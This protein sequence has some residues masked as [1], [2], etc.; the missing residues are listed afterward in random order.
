M[1]EDAITHEDAKEEYDYFFDLL[2]DFRQSNPV[3]FK[4]QYKKAREPDVL[5]Y[6]TLD[7]AERRKLAN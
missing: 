5:A 2:E 3:F 6:L 7:E 4:W 1:E